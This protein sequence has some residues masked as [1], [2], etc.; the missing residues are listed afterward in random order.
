MNFWNA[1]LRKRP[2]RDAFEAVDVV[3]DDN[4]KN[5]NNNNDTDDDN[6]RWELC[7]AQITTRD[8]RFVHTE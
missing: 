8:A 1:I 3:R 7:S 6:E 5:N 2:H 4:N